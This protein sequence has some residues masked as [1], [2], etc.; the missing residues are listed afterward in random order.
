MPANL[1]DRL[2]DVRKRRGMTQQE[3]ARESGVSVS[4]IRKLEQG[5]RQDARLETVRRLAASLRVPTMRLVAES[6][7]DGAS[8][9]TLDQ[10]ATVRKALTAPLRDIAELDEP[11]TPEG[12]RD[13]LSAAVPLFSGDRFTELRAVL[14]PLL[15]DADTVARLGPEGR[16]VRVRLLQLTGWLLTQTRQF[17]AAEWCL[18]AA[19][20]G[21]A[22]RLQGASTVNTMC[23]LLLRQGKLSE[24][25]ELASQWADD[26]EPRLSR[27]TPDEL[28]AWGWLLL[29]LSAAAVRDN[30]AEEA[31]DALR[32]AHSAAVALGREFAPGDD[33]LRAYGPVT[34]TLKRT[35]N[36]MVL[37]RPD[38]VLK[39]AAK[40][41]AGGFRPTS[42][43]RNRHLLDVA[44]AYARTR[45]YG[46]AV[47]TLASIRDAAPEW[48][49]N[50]RYARDILGRIVAHRRTLTGE[51]RSLA[52]TVG[53]P[54]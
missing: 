54:V 33:F 18:G 51:M 47:D 23:W 25:R 15:R 22:D 31:E 10:W 39:L 21:S 32:L 46:H 40:I 20:D 8:P 5:E 43:N 12:V 53:L 11:P 35:E 17:E 37:D 45:Q 2:R 24:A 16:A 41:P 4:L 26:T 50:Q 14:P 28:S 36:A 19:L 44:N 48:L 52:D 27:A 42:N 34:V 1:G 49:P 6:A 13:A 38:V 7:E 9:A 30:R 3:L 29:R